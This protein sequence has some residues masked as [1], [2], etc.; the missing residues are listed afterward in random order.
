MDAI[1]FRQG[2]WLEAMPAKVDLLYTF[3]ENEYNGST[4]LQ[5]NVKD[6]Q[7]SESQE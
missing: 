5:L 6:I 2:H 1:A 3:E 7:P 4:S